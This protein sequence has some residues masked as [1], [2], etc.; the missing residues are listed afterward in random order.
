MSAGCVVLSGCSGGGKSTLLLELRRRGYGAVDEP[1][2]RVVKAEIDKGGQAL[3]WID[4]AAFA[5]RA[6]ELAIEDLRAAESLSGWVFFDRGLVDA[7]VAREH[8]TGELILDRLG[9][10]Y[11]YHLTVFLAPPWPE[12]YVSDPERKHG[13]DDAIG[14]YRRLERAY[15]ALGYRVVV[16][17]KAS[18]EARADFVL[19]HLRADMA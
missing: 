9:Q 18:V 10:S 3:P 2:R 14:E 8:A 17:P 6:I 16:L 15:P 7:A 5:Q 11:R 4:L 12:I 1:G 19:A 13:F